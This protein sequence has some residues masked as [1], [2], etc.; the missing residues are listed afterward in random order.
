[1]KN[2]TKTTLK[3]F[4]NHAKKHGWLGF[5]VFISIIGASVSN[6][7]VPLYFKKFF[8]VLTSGVGKTEGYEAMIGILIIIGII[9]LIHWLFWRMENLS[10]T[11]FQTKVIT[12]LDRFSFRKIHEHSFS[13]FNNSFTGSLVKKVNY[14]SKSFEAIADI[15]TYNIIPLITTIAF[16]TIV[17]ARENVLL[18][19]I[20][21]AW[22]MIYV[23]INY[24]LAQIKLKYDIIATEAKTIQT[25]DLADTIT[26]SSNVK[27]FNG[28]ERENQTFK[29]LSDD[30]K[31][32]RQFSW[33]LENIFEGIQAF[34]M[35][36][37][38]LIFFYIGLK[39]WQKDMFS[40]SDFVLLQSYVLMVMMRI[41]N[42]GKVI[43]RLY[44]HL[45]DAEEMVEIIETPVE[46]IDHKK[47][48]ELNITE[49]KIEFN[50]VD[51]C[52]YKTR[53]VLD[54]F[55]MKIKSQEKVAL[56]GPSGA[57]K[58]TVIKLLLRNHD[59]TSGKI[60]IDGQRILY[61]TQDSL[62]QNISLVPQDPILFHRS[63]IENIRYSKPEASDKEVVEAAKLANAHEFIKGFP[64]GYKTYVGERGVK[65]SGGE[66]QRVAIARAILRNAPILVL[67]E[68][69]SSLDSESEKLIQHALERLMQD[70]TVIVIAHRLSTIRKMDRIIFMEEGKI[71]EE[72]IHEDLIK[73]DNGK[74]RKMWE[75]QARGF[76]Y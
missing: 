11:Y 48:Q 40:V 62:W 22:V 69:T 67:D 64:D 41:W 49:G 68:A 38:E 16:I 33:N 42:F 46:I 45:A 13:F 61:A 60:L 53:K 20:I 28:I 1:M 24:F 65:L 52:Y 66:R 50:M 6:T 12:D 54:K 10:S 34:L 58:S 27:M 57:G 70:K 9:E 17:L 63:L 32:K 15:L 3:I 2:N 31:K 74:Y 29:D 4:F 21:I 5:L 73:L 39:L 44:Q 55:N 18:G 19:L 43:R 59:I 56:I 37:F 51:F 75:V 26:N 76:I 7:V 30:L 25:G 14:F 35:I 71:Q 72:G 36:G 23:T 47:A 8:D